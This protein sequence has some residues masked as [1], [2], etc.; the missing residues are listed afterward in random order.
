MPGGTV[1]H[2]FGSTT[3]KLGVLS[4]SLNVLASFR[5]ARDTGA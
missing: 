3:T 4:Q 5:L 2:A 1:K